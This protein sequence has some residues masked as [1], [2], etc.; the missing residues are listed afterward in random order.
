MAALFYC[1][2]DQSGEALC[3]MREAMPSLEIRAWPDTLNKEEIDRAIVWMPPENFFAGLTQLKTVYSISAG[4]DYL[5]TNSD[6]SDTTNIVRLHDAGMGDKMA[7]Y[8]LYGVLHAQRCMPDLTVAQRRSC[9][10]KSISIPTPDR[11]S[12]GILGAGALG[13]KVAE[14]LQLNDFV[15]STW[16]RS[17]KR[18]PHKHYVGQDELDLFLSKCNVLVCLLPL[19]QETTG[20]L[21]TELF[22]S[23]PDKAYVIN[24]AR[25]PHLRVDDLVAA[26]D[27]GKLSGAMLDVFETEP[28]PTDSPLWQHERIVLTPHI[29][30]DSSNEGSAAQIA[31]SMKEIDSGGTPLGLVDRLR[32]Y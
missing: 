18:T 7:N 26:I 5:L 29:A 30:A 19:T 8:V 10:E 9:W 32:G 15:V 11:I 24:P 28:L 16:S 17:A 1:R 3:A 20:I 22:N 13:L 6:L 27:T 23:L 4:V 2:G 25:G 14:R 31:Q 12:V 21:N